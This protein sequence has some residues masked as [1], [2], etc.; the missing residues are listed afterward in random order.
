MKAILYSSSTVIEFYVSISQT[1]SARTKFFV[2]RINFPFRKA[3]RS[4]LNF[5]LPPSAPSAVASFLFSI[6]HL[7]FRAVKLSQQ[8]IY[9]QLE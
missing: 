6:S 4:I 2:G 3:P 5:G 7:F 1:V 8:R 9:S